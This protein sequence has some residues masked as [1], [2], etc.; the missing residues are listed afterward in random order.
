MVD[1]RMKAEIHNHDMMCQC[2]KKNKTKQNSTCTCSQ[3]QKHDF[4]RWNLSWDLAAILGSTK[5]EWSHRH[6]RAPWCSSQLSPSGL[7]SANYNGR[8]WTLPATAGQRRAAW[9]E[10]NRQEKNKQRCVDC[11]VFLCRL[12]REIRECEICPFVIYT[13]LPHKHSGGLLLSLSTCLLKLSPV[14]IT[15][16]SEYLHTKEFSLHP[17]GICTTQL[18]NSLINWITTNTWNI[19]PNREACSTGQKQQTHKT[20]IEIANHTH[21]VNCTAK[22]YMSQNIVIVAFWNINL[23]VWDI[24]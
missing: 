13:Q 3:G 20:W 24:Y 8:P 6:Q 14:K 18:C 11:F 17:A 1:C 22:L 15:F 16:T 9:S 5:G 19:F 7:G 23:L 21:T 10:K 2:I 12:S 4:Q